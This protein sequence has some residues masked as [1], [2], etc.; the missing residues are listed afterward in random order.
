[1]PRIGVI[2]RV[3][4]AEIFNEAPIIAENGRQIKSPNELKSLFISPNL[5]NEL[6]VQLEKNLSDKKEV[7]K[8]N[9]IIEN[10]IHWALV[11]GFVF[12]P[13]GRLETDLMV[14]T[15]MPFTLYPS[16]FKRAHFENVVKLQPQINELVYRIATTPSTLEKAFEK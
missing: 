16:P 6:A 9:R 10:A 2:L 8:I 3:D 13:K 14:V 15:H 5:F 11:N 4:M 7:L 1:M 12:I